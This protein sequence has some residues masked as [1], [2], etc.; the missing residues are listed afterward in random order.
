MAGGLLQAGALG[1]R[2]TR[3]AGLHLGGALALKGSL[4]TLGGSLFAGLCPLPELRVVHGTTIA[5]GPVPGTTAEVHLMTNAQATLGLLEVDADFARFLTD[6]ERAEAQRLAVPVDEVSRGAVDVTALLRSEGAFGAVVLDGM[7]MHRLRIGDQFAARLLGP[8]DFVFLSGVP[9]SML[10]GESTCSATG[11]TRLAILGSEVLAAV[12]RWPRLAAGI[13]VRAAEQAD[14]MAAQ[15][16][17]CQ[18]PRVDQRVLSLLW[19]LAESWGRVGP[20]GTALPIA[21]THDSLGALI[22]ARRPTVTLALGELSE[23]GAIVRQDRGWLLLEPPP[24]AATTAGSVD[25][26]TLL[27]FESTAWAVRPNERHAGPSHEEL[28]STLAALRD[29]HAI[30]R[31]RVTAQLATVRRTRERCADLRERIAA[32]R[33]K[34]RAPSSG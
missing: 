24:G 6:Q 16:A 28:L 22:G 34:L 3:L 14:R 33:L 7:L 10:L 20:A 9:R 17:I 11:T 23:R 12:R 18:L 4:L 25:A 2:G 30:S 8:G 15:L 29:E 21:L 19:L 5:L 26:P 27:P 31:D 13:Y 32:E 1:S